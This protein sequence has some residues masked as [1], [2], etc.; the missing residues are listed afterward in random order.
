M[1]YIFFI[2]CSEVQSLLIAAKDIDAARRK[3]IQYLDINLE[4]SES[5]IYIYPTGGV[6]RTLSNDES[7]VL[8]DSSIL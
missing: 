3:A 4:V 1:L 2:K 5:D 6:Y 7:I 8:I